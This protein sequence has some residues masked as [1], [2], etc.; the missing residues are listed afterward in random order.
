[1]TGRRG[2]IVVIAA[3]LAIALYSGRDILAQPPQLEVSVTLSQDTIGMDEQAVLE[4]EVTGATQDLPEPNLPTL[5][6]FEVYSQG[7]STNISIVN[8]RVEAS[9]TNRYLLV[10]VRAGSYPIENIAVVYQNRRFVGNAVTLTVLSRG[11]SA[12][13]QLEQR[14]MDADG[15]SKDFFLE[16]SVDNPRPYVNQQT[17]LTLKFFIAVQYYGSPELV[18]PTTT[19]FW[20][21]LLGTKGPYQQ[22]VNNRTYRVI[23]RKYALFP[24]ATGEQTIGRATISVTVPARQRTR[25]P[26]PFDIFGMLGSGEEVQI[27]SRPLT[28]NVRAL[29]EAGRPGDFTGTIGRF[30][31]KATPAKREVEVNQPVSVNLTITGVGNIKSVAEPVI[32]ELTDFRVYKASSNESVSKLDDR[33][34]GTKVFEEVFIPKRPGLLEIPSLTF[35]FFDPEAERYRIVKTDPIALQVSRGEGYAATPDLPYTGPDIKIGAE[36]RDIRY[37]KTQPGDLGKPRELLL[38][39]PLYLAVNAVPVLALIATVIMRRRREKLSGDIGYARSRR[40]SKEA[41]R[42]LGQARSLASVSTSEKFFAECSAAL[43]SFI[44]DKLNV[45]PHGLTGDR[46]S[47]L[48]RD[49][50]A[51][52]QLIRDILAFLDQCGFARYAPST[53]SQPDI[54]QALADAENLMVRLEEVR[55]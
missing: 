26:D 24:T 44:G 5:P 16:A 32:P 39:S 51:D 6:M 42:R 13:P 19:G 47:D 23:E 48:L 33:I 31:F 17:T 15:A 27:S 53:V 41:R 46:I 9:V 18:E 43:L 45:S 25:R 2:Y 49:R 54:D 11:S 40:A 3:V 28:V 20:T 55:F 50:S 10:P 35:S 4:V 37:I 22:R 29:P 21:E 52:E 8:G 7:R 14:A 12:P 30:T 1:M 38:T 34:G 36:A